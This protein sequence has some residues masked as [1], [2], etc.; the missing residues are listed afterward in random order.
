MRRNKG[1]GEA[2]G[3]GAGVCGGWGGT[4]RIEKSERNRSVSG[5]WKGEVREGGLHLNGVEWE[6][7]GRA[8]A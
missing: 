5:D 3:G 4:G 8:R 2:D 7:E 1:G 6:S